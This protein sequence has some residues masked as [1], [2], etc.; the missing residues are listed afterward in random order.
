MNMS[1]GMSRVKRKLMMRSR[2]RDLILIF[3]LQLDFIPR[4]V[5]SI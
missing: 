4:R 3:Y 2:A 1:S 5:W